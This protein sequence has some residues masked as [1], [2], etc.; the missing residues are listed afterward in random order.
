MTT[1]ADMLRLPKSHPARFMHFYGR[2]VGKY[3]LLDSADFDWDRIAERIVWA[4]RCPFGADLMA[5]A[6]TNS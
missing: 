5:C 2:P 3:T 6:E 1:D 4:F